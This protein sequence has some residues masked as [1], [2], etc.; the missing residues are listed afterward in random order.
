MSKGILQWNISQFNAGKIC[1][2]SHSSQTNLV[3]KD[4]NLHASLK[5]MFNETKPKLLPT[6]EHEEA[7]NPT[8]QKNSSTVPGRPCSCLWS[9]LGACPGPWEEPGQLPEPQR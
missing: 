1:K 6:E 3:M 2:L 4:T 7:G 9:P 8:Q 5:E